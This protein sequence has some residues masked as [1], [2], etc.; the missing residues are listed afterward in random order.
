MILAA[1]K[2]SSV[3]GAER[4]TGLTSGYT[5]GKGTPTP[6]S[7]CV[8][9]A[10][11]L[12]RCRGCVNCR[13]CCR[14]CLPATTR[15]RGGYFSSAFAASIATCRLPASKC[16]SHGCSSMA[17][18]TAALHSGVPISRSVGVCTTPWGQCAPL[19]VT[20]PTLLRS[21]STMATTSLV[22]QANKKAKTGTAPPWTV[23][24][25]F[26]EASLTSHRCPSSPCLP[27]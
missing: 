23:L 19:T 3:A 10:L 26:R 16:R 6:S 13:R 18:W 5:N 22:L 27:V 8:A 2:L 7:R 17:R 12:P 14:R 11:M 20:V 4:T 24:C 15:P 25:R 1:V 9:A 21:T